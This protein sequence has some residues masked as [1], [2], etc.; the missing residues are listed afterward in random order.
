ME[1]KGL[2]TVVVAFGTSVERIHLNQTNADPALGP[3]MRSVYADGTNPH[4]F[5]TDPMVGKALSKAI[6]R[7]LLVDIGYGAGG[8]ATCNVLPAPELYASTANDDCLVQDIEEAKA[9]L[10]EAGWVPGS[11]GIR[12]KDGVRLSV[13][14]QTSTNAVRQD[15]QALVKQWWDEL[16]VETE[17]RNVDASVFFGGDPAS[18]DT[19]QKFYADLEMYTN[20]FSGV[21]PEAYMANWS[22]TRI[23]GPNTQ[24]QGENIQRF[25]MP[26]YDALVAEMANTADLSQRGEL[27]KQM[28][29]MI[30]QSYSIIPLVHRGGVS[31]HANTLQGIRMSDWDSELWNIKDWYREEG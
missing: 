30:M 16:G 11:D 1:A 29:D 17:L 23:P 24:W 9:I 5:L 31:A 14:Y 13:T 25:C 10:D 27:A 19:F 26:E 4:P 18:P 12:E 22:C 8:Q 3:D 6:D 15:T 28:N 21:D 2:G 20:N 7:Q